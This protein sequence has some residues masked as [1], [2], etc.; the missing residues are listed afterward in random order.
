ME[1][2]KRKSKE[3][4]RWR[5]PT[6]GWKITLS[7]EYGGGGKKKKCW[8][9]QYTW[10][11]VSEGMK[12][13][14]K[15]QQIGGAGYGSGTHRSVSYSYGGGGERVWLDSWQF[16]GMMDTTAISFVKVGFGSTRLKECCNCNWTQ[17][18]VES[19]TVRCLLHSPLFVFV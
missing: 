12:E 1:K 7:Q 3:D 4:Y 17:V 9:V 6:N 10:R 11:K 8:W 15:V 13:Y 14:W 18:Q 5:K 2:K 16:F 19:Y